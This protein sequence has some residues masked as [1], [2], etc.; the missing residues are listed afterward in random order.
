MTQSNA[1]SVLLKSLAPLKPFKLWVIFTCGLNTIF[2]ILPPLFIGK[3]TDSLINLNGGTVAQ[4]VN[5][6]LLFFATICVC[7][8]LNW[9]QN[10]NWFKMTQ[11]GAMCVRNC[12]FD[13]VIQNNNQ[14]FV[15]NSK[16]DVA[17][18][19]IND[20]AIWAETQMIKTPVLFLNLFH[21]AIIYGILFY[22]NWILAA[23]V[24]AMSLIYFLFYLKM[25]KSIRKNAVK[26]RQDM[27]TIMHITSEVLSG[28]ESVKLFQKEQ[29]FS[30]RFQQHTGSYFTNTAK[31]QLFQ[32]LGSSVSSFISSAMPV[33]VLLAG[34]FLVAEGRVSVGEIISFYAYV[35]LVIEPLQNLSNYSMANQQAKAVEERLTTLFDQVAEETKPPV[36]EI[37]SLD[38]KNLT[39]QFENGR[40]LYS[41]FHLSIKHGDRL[42]FVGESGSGKSTLLKIILG[43]IQL[44]NGQFQVNEVPLEDIS[45]QSYLKAISA[46]PQNNFVFEGTVK[47][48]ILFEEEKDLTEI[49]SMVNLSSE[50]LEKKATLLSGGE[51][52]RVCLARA[53]AKPCDF[54]VLD[55]PTSALDEETERKFIQSLDEYLKKHHMGLLVVTHRKAILEICD[56][57]VSN[58]SVL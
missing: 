38:F 39:F 29:Y 52:Q 56:R 18:R 14:F 10:Y 16:G 35:A 6:A 41:N 46:L 28:I 43:Q 34:I 5:I 21:L 53:L 45:Y 8:V 50:Y 1:K 13:K 48:N 26:Q 2:Q 7:F 9:Y 12:L 24:V 40:K 42:A 3:L 51:V 17:N 20:G 11:K 37:K 25:N 27:S 57:Q 15:E 30:K 22:F 58:S 23:I 44:N 54:L 36:T 47:E 19:L 49:L 33:A 31:V 55:E 32:T 4:A